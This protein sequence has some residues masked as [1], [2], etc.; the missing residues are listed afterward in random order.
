MK[1]ESSV[2]ILDSNLFVVILWGRLFDLWD[3]EV[4]WEILM[5][6]PTH[7]KDDVYHIL[8]YWY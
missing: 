8:M 3:A 7:E 6:K 2:T 1:N 5:R 4:V